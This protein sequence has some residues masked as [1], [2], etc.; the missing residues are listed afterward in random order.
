[1]TSSL[2]IIQFQLSGFNT[3]LRLRMIAAHL[4]F[5][6]FFREKREKEETYLIDECTN[7]PTKNDKNNTILHISQSIMDSSYDIY[8]NLLDHRN[9]M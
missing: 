9:N 4:F 3:T 7:K 2:Q 1:M 8:D 6:F 5:F